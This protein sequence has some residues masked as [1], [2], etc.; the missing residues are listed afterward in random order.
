MIEYK[1]MVIEEV[2]KLA[3]IDRSEHIDSVYEMV[4]GRLVETLSNHE[5]DSW[6]IDT[7][8]EIKDRF[9]YELQHG[10][11]A[12]GAFHDEKLVGFGVLAHKFR[13]VNNDILQ[14]DLMY[15]SRLYRRRGIASRILQDLTM[16]ARQRGAKEL[17]ISSTETQSAVSFYKHAGSKLADE[18]DDELF[19]KEPLDIHMKIK[20]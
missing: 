5:C 4:E 19:N 15:V 12:V 11:L 9:I 3:D 10:G 8:E 17:Y 16:E 18:I 2:N 1:K 6:S 20:L 7:L 13:G 14:V